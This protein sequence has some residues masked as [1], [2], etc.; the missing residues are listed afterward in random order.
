METYYC[1]E[2]YVKLVR[3]DVHR[4]YLVY[5]YFIFTYLQEV[6]S[7]FSPVVLSI[8]S[9][10]FRSRL[11]LF[12]PFDSACFGPLSL[13]GAHNGSEMLHDLLY[14]CTGSVFTVLSCLILLVMYYHSL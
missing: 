1:S 6:S 9:F 12:S 5:V 10:R 14:R 7:G 13:H 4:N 8:P 3:A 2:S 11:C